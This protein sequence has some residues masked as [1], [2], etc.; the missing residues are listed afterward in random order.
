[1]SL[2]VLK[3]DIKLTPMVIRKP[4]VYF[5]R[6]KEEIIPV[7]VSQDYCPSFTE[8]WK[9]QKVRLPG[10]QEKTYLI[11]VDD[12]GLF[13]ELLCISDAMVKEEVEITIRHLRSK[14][15]SEIKD[16]SWWRRLF[17]KF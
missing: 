14:V 12:R 7:S 6:L 11:K 1:M 8:C 4:V 15:I 2:P 3:V 16:L 10:G 17:K 13:S 5:Q 9:T